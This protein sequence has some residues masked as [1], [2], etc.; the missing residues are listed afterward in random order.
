MDFRLDFGGVDV[1]VQA[2]QKAKARN[3][4]II[5]NANLGALI[6][7]A[8]LSFSYAQMLE[9][10]DAE[11]HRQLKP[12][13]QAGVQPD[14]VPLENEGSAGVLYDIKLPSG[15][16]HSRGTGNNS[17]VSLSQLQAELSSP[18]WAYICLSAVGWVHQ[19]ADFVFTQRHPTCRDG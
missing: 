6:P 17:E 4:K 10:I 18:N 3:M 7:E 8:W 9:A 2:A 13:L 1:Q 19:A 15:A 5:H 14:I 11:M 16:L 12:F